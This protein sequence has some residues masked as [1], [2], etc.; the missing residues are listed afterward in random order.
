MLGFDLV[1]LVAVDGNRAGLGSV[2]LARRTA[3]RGQHD[4]QHRRSQ[5]SEEKPKQHVLPIKRDRGG[6]LMRAARRH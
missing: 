5:Q 4:S 2:A 3:E 6:G 1:E